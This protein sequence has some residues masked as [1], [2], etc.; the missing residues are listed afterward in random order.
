M[1]TPRC[2][3]CQYKDKHH[4]FNLVTCKKCNVHVH[5]E[6]Y[7]LTDM[8]AKKFESG[9]PAC[10]AVNKEFEGRPSRGVV[11]MVTQLKRPTEC[12][13]CSVSVGN[14]AMHPLYDFDGK[15]GRQ[16]ILP[17]GKLAWVHTLCASS[18]CQNRGTPGC[19][20]GCDVT[21]NAHSGGDSEESSDGSNEGSGSDNG[22]L[23][24]VSI[25]HFVIC[26]PSDKGWWQH[27]CDHRQLT[28]IG[29]GKKDIHKSLR[30]PIQCTAG[31]CREYDQFAK[32]HQDTDGC[33]QAMH[34]GCAMWGPNRGRHRRIYFYPGSQ[35]GEGEPVAEFYCPQHA[36]DAT[37]KNPS[38]PPMGLLV[39]QGTHTMSG[40]DQPE[41]VGRLKRLLESPKALKRTSKTHAQ[42]PHARTS[43]AE[44][45][46][47]APKRP[48]KIQAQMRTSSAESPKVPKRPSKTLSHMSLASMS[49]VES[50]KTSKRPSKAH[51]IGAKTVI[52]KDSLIRKQ[53]VADAALL[54][55]SDSN[56]SLLSAA[57]PKKKSPAITKGIL[58]LFAA[59]GGGGGGGGG[60]EIPDLNN[61]P[62]KRLGKTSRA[63]GS[64]VTAAE[65]T[66]PSPHIL[67]NLLSPTS[68]KGLPPPPAYQRNSSITKS[69]K[70]T[71]TPKVPKKRK[72]AVDVVDD[73]GPADFD[74]DTGAEPTTKPAKKLSRVRRRYISESKTDDDF[75]DDDFDWLGTM[76]P[77]VEKA[78]S[79]AK[80]DGHDLNEIMEARRYYWRRRSGIY[81]S[82]FLGLWDK[83]R[84]KVA[85]DLV[86]Q[87]V[88]Q[89]KSAREP[90][91]NVVIE[92]NVEDGA[93]RSE[94]SGKN[95]WANMW[96][97]S[98]ASLFE[99]GDWDSSQI[100]MKRNIK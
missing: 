3:I 41:D 24:A 7:G 36:R 93:D 33:V 77:D 97:N 92:F 88:P 76:I 81:G 47:W 65:T 38:S 75:Y 91:G 82:D 79:L 40:Y 46:K 11:Q 37:I 90:G 27:I 68:I 44:S 22:T 100:V 30:I 98:A 12:A 54:G 55:R 60:L 25:H 71:K 31:D 39:R 4:G 45:P 49:S 28:C 43:S 1:S 5:Q 32:K 86:P 67:S 20:Y 50:P 66:V 69:T 29:C 34:V 6:C 21:G 85:S 58:E 35:T 61:I 72:G 59:D 10:K 42:M 89:E 74:Q 56:K 15:R 8:T 87:V 57:I 64:Y 23:D 70:S 16:L 52:R 84:E 2:D 19:V 48:S 63:L 18:I 53:T 73:G 62:R 78:L 14:H 17:N 51:A 96:K 80:K 94:F 13:L 83:V 26:N 99:F 9:C 95:K